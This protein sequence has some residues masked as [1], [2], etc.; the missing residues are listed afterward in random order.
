[1][2]VRKYSFS[3]RVVDVW[4]SLPDDAVSANGVFLFELRLDE[5]WKDQ[6]ILHNYEAKLDIRLR[7]ICEVEELVI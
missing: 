3:N 5:Y 2:D 4:N 6:G 1:M 7:G